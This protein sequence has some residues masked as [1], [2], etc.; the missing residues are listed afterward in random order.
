MQSQKGI[1]FVE[2]NLL[3]PSRDILLFSNG[4]AEGKGFV[5]LDVSRAGIWKHV[6]PTV[7]FD[8]VSGR[9]IVLAGYGYVVDMPRA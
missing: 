5:R 1:Q 8:E 7:S 9:I 2:R 6:K 3:E 4:D